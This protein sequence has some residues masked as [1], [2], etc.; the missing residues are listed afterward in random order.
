[1]AP[2][3]DVKPRIGAYVRARALR[4]DGGKLV[5]G[6]VLEVRGGLVLL[7]LPH[8]RWCELAGVKHLRKRGSTFRKRVGQ[9]SNLSH[10]LRNN[11][12]VK[13]DTC[14]TV[15]D[16]RDFFSLNGGRPLSP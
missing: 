9:P 3:A 6:V 7:D 8:G 4:I 1:M 15:V 12:E 16:R 10:P 11:C 14:E 5:R 13:H 2:S